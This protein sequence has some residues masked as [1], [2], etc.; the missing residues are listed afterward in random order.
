MA[1]LS[2]VSEGSGPS[3]LPKKYPLIRSSN[4]SGPSSTGVSSN[5]SNAVSQELPLTVAKTCK[6]RRKSKESPKLRKLCESNLHFAD[7]ETFH[8]V[9]VELSL[10]EVNGREVVVALQL[11]I[12]LTLQSLQTRL[13]HV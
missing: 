1:P 6:S 13:C 5:S 9:E 8:E 4:S 2:S 7:V 12:R 3:R 10:T 11:S